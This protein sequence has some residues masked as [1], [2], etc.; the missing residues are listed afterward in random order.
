MAV[1]RSILPECK[2][3]FAR[4]PS[5]NLRRRAIAILVDVSNGAKLG[6][7]LEHRA[8]VGHLSDCFKVYFDEDDA[9]A[10]RFWLVYRLLPDAVTAVEVQAV[11]VGRRAATQAYVD[12]ARRLGRLT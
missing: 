8:S 11:A 3:D 1:R 12:A 9:R 10:P 5:D 2:R 4:L 7:P 6:A